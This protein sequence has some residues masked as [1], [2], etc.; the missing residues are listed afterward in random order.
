MLYTNVGTELAHKNGRKFRIYT[1]I[2]IN[3][4]AEEVEI[5]LGNDGNSRTRKM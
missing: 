4:V 5:D 3:F 2:N 1:C